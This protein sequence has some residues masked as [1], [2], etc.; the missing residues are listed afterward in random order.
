VIGSTGRLLTIWTVTMRVIRLDMITITLNVTVIMCDM[1]A[2]MRDMTDHCDI[3]CIRQR[4]I[5][6][7]QQ[8]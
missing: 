7:P 6:I 2:I 3:S 4:N 8:I 1:I 5:K